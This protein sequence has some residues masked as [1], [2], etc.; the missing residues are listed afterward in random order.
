MKNSTIC[1]QA[2][3]SLAAVLLCSCSSSKEEPGQKAMSESM[4]ARILSKDMNK[5]SSFESA[6][7]TG[8]SGMGSYLEKQGYNAK[9]Y[10]GKTQYQTPKTLDQ[11][12]YSG[13][14]ARSKLAKQR[15]Q[16]ADN[17]SRLA[18]RAFGTKKAR[19]AGQT[20]RQQDQ[21]FTAGGDQFKTAAYGEA[22]RSQA[23]NNRPLIV[24]PDGGRVDETPYSE[25]D[26]RRMVNRR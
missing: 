20:A 7:V 16:G 21:A 15:Y 19:E 18:D 23:E 2:L 11:K 13:A 10:A 14:E 9:K 8:N 1:V 24:K 5:R 22:A 6:L 3:L 25:D 12:S 26:I 17:K 4:A